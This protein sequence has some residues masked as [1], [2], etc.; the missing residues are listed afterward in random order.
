MLV[1]NHT[2]N[3][4]LT[5]AKDPSTIENKPNEISF[6]RTQADLSEDI[7]TLLRKDFESYAQDFAEEVRKEKEGE[8]LTTQESSYNDPYEKVVSEGTLLSLYA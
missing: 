8:F 7:N 6:E 2:F 4:F 3:T 1:S 5:Q